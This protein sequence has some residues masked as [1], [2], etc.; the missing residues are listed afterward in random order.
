MTARHRTAAPSTRICI[1]GHELMAASRRLSMRRGIFVTCYRIPRGRRNDFPPSRNS[2]RFRRVFVIDRFVVDVAPHNSNAL[3]L[4]GGSLSGKFD[5]LSISELDEEWKGH[6]NETWAPNRY[7]EVSKR[8][9]EACISLGGFYRQ[10]R[11]ARTDCR[12]VISFRKTRLCHIAMP[13]LSDCPAEPFAER[14]R[15]CKVAVLA[16][17]LSRIRGVFVVYRARAWFPSYVVYVVLLSDP[18]GRRRPCRCYCH[19]R[20]RCHTSD[21]HSL[22]AL[23]QQVEL[24]RSF[25]RKNIF[26]GKTF[27]SYSA[28]RR[29]VTSD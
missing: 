16:G 1:S 12:C 14:L 6:R 4:A 23:Q 9:N 27:P 5:S 8:R 20:H 17:F 15:G 13:C 24:A 7:H 19:G 2:L 25:Q 21:T 22:L 11:E 29:S 10:G 3:S 18:I 26:Q 28:S